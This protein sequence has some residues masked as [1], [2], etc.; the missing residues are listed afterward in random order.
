MREQGRAATTHD[1]VAC[2]GLTGGTGTN[3]RPPRGARGLCR[4]AMTCARGADSDAVE[5]D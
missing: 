4:S 1:F 3:A 2:V 5:P